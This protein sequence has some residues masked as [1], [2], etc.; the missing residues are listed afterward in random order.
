MI[1]ILRD[2]EW[3]SCGFVLKIQFCADRSEFCS[4]NEI[5][6]ILQTFNFVSQKSILSDKS[7]MCV[8]KLNFMRK[9]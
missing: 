4:R 9:Y 3:D 6:N 2:A 8:T 5:Y 7:L 1:G